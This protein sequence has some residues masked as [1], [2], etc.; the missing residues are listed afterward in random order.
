MA[1]ISLF[2]NGNHKNILLEDFSGG[3]AVQSNQHL[4]VHGDSAMILDPG[5]H[6]IYNRVFA[7][8]QSVVGKATLRYLFLSHQDPDIVAA[9][10]G[11]LMTTDADA[12]VSKLWLRFIPHFGLDRLVE[13]RLHGIEDG[14]MRL[15]LGGSD[16]WFIPAHFLH[17]AGNFQVYDPVS[18][19]LYTGDLGASI[20]PEYRE[21]SDFE[22][23]CASMDG[24][25]RRYMASGRAMKLWADMVRGLDIEIIAPQ[26]GALFKGKQMVDKFISHFERFECGVD[27]IAD[28]YR[29]PAR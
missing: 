17:S 9:C 10:N 21:V 22:A 4:I 24:F 23:H 11:W 7:E 5:G 12:Y 20:G 26:H 3:L 2:D 25:H 29:I 6:K 19:I 27:L 18:K 28:A 1:S 13:N 8:T 15:D 14:G 16:L